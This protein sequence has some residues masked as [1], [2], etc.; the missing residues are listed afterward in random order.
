[1]LEVNQ[2]ICNRLAEMPTPHSQALPLLKMNPYEAEAA[3][4][5]VLSFLQQTTLQRFPNSDLAERLVRN[6]YLNLLE[7]PAIE[8]YSRTIQPLPISAP[9]TPGEAVEAAAVDLPYQISPEDKKAALQILTDLQQGR[10]ML[11]L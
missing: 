3:E 11:P 10:I 6:I 8:E 2:T 5:K 7:A 1:M 9:R 4:D